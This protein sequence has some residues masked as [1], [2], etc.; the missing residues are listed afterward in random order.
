MK[1]MLLDSATRIAVLFAVLA[2]TWTFFSD[3]AVRGLASDPNVHE[4]LDTYT[5]WAFVAVVTA[6]LYFE[7]RRAE[8]D[9]GVLS[10]VLRSSH[11]AIIGKTPEGIIT[12]WNRGAEMMYGYSAK[13][14]IGH[15]ASIL[16]PPD[17]PD[18][19][20]GLLEGVRRGEQVDHH[21]SVRVRKDGDKLHVCVSISP[22]KS[23]TGR[24][25]GAAMINHDVSQ[26]KRA[27]AAARMAEVGRLARGLVHEIRNPLNAM[28]MQIAV[29]QAKLKNPTEPNID[30]ASTQLS[31]LEE[32]VLR[33]QDLARGFL[34]YGRPPEDKLEEIDLSGMLREVAEFQKPALTAQGI[35]VTL[36]VVPGAG[37]S[38]VLMDRARLRQVFLNLA[39][40]ARQAMPGGGTLSLR[41][42]MQ[43]L[44]TVI[45]EVR[46]S[47]GGIAASQLGKVFDAFYSTKDEGH[48]LGLAIA[49]K[50]I[51]RG[52][53]TISVQSEVG[54]GSCFK[55]TLPLVLEP[56]RE[57]RELP[58]ASSVS[59]IKS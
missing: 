24:V 59:E 40:N 45:V 49:S 31:R 48:G 30:V 14:I 51:E 18:E 44:R 20:R 32:E 4:R 3:R 15:S 53:G 13:E 52:G 19:F 5:G 16:V 6:L 2:G 34:E 9:L 10:A 25:T 36:D 57:A 27:E 38:I 23:V 37:N 41:V 50:I 28:R 33:V 47:G 46:D 58:S 21:E 54:L 29:I 12:S 43:P 22:I 7:R 42:A 17:R 55:I 56:D 39:E 26:H 1:Y 11:E 8:R 35:S